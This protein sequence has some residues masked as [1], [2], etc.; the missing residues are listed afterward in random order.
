MEAAL[1]LRD[2]ALT[3][4]ATIFLLTTYLGLGEYKQVDSLARFSLEFLRKQVDETISSTVA[5]KRLRATLLSCHGMSLGMLGMF[6][7]GER[8]W[9]PAS[10]RQIRSIDPGSPEAAH[11]RICPLALRFRP[12]APGRSGARLGAFSR[13]V[14]ILE[15]NKC[16]WHASWSWSCLV[17][18]PA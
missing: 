12:A 3:G 7:E 8:N 11:H 16:I 15:E 10:S 9:T 18:R 6:G 17:L 4:W 14:R 5:Y 1:S 2:P 13:R